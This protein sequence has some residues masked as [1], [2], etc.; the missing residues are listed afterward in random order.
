VRGSG[1]G[2]EVSLERAPCAAIKGI[3]RLLQATR[4]RATS[5]SVSGSAARR[6]LHQVVAP[7]FG[8]AMVAERADDFLGG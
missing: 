5:A 2:A 8:G 6:R 3:G 7:A 4:N 1:K